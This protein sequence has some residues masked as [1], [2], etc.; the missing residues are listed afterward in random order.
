[1][2]YSDV[3]RAAQRLDVAAQ[4]AAR[5]L[6]QFETVTLRVAA[7][8]GALV[9]HGRLDPSSGRMTFRTVLTPEQPPQTASE[10]ATC[11]AA[12]A[13]EVYLDAQD[14]QRLW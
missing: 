10:R 2:T 12:G 14:Q 9:T 7:D 5:V 4:K 1:M 11:L 13:R 6:A 8:G 3:D